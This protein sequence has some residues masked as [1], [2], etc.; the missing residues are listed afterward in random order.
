[1][2]GLDKNGAATPKLERVS[3]SSKE[4]ANPA[5]ISNF[6][7]DSLWHLL[8]EMQL[9]KTESLPL[10]EECVPSPLACV[11]EACTCVDFQQ[12]DMDVICM[13]CGTVQ[14]KN[15]DY[16]AEWR[17]YGFN[18]NKSSNPTRCGMPTNEF[19][20]KSSL[21]TVI[22]TERMTKNFYEM[23][24][25][26]KYHMWNSMPYKERSLY[27]VINRLN[28]KA[29]N[30]GI[31]SSIIEDAKVMY[32]K[33][34]EMK[35][36]RGEN[37]NGLIASSIYM[38]CK[39]NGVPRSAKEIASIFNL[40]ITTMT[41][42]CKKF[43]EIMRLNVASTSPDDFIVRFCSKLDRPDIVE[44]SLYIVRA[45][46][47]YSIV[48]ENAPP[49]IAAGSIYLCS[50]VRN[51]GVTKKEISKACEISEVTINKCYKKLVMY[52]SYLLPVDAQKSSSN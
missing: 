3:V 20:P 24:R 52:V 41:K 15:I 45:A 46:D 39:N 42:G 23:A 10:E 29:T 13:T 11:N 19:L 51:H 38:S 27:N 1:M 22:G 33:L 9:E 35:I 44:D 17:Y 43:H 28:T 25:I 31:S 21:G 12:D 47:K 26:R 4:P 6:D 30:G 2:S 8:S 37:R 14:Y 5:S 40:N 16:G 32:K 49:S 48:S 18:D 34:S 36:S 50:M 7:D